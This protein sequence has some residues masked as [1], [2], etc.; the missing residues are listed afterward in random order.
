[1]DSRNHGNHGVAV[2]HLNLTYR[3]ALQ[4]LPTT[5]RL[6]SL[7][8]KSFFLPSLQLFTLQIDTEDKLYEKHILYV[9]MQ[10]MN[11]KCVLVHVGILKNLSFKRVILHIIQC[12]FVY[13]F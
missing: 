8:V 3:N 9:A 10:Q 13:S 2:I 7:R 4:F 11:S 6:I 5:A 1:M 12:V